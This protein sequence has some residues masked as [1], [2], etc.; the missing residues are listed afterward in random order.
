MKAH[1]ALKCP[2]K[3]IFIFFLRST[4]QPWG[5]SPQHPPGGFEVGRKAHLGASWLRE[6]PSFQRRLGAP[7]LLC[8]AFKDHRMEGRS[9]GNV[10]IGQL[11]SLAWHPCF[12]YS[13]NFSDFQWVLLHHAGPC[14][15]EQSVRHS[16]HFSS[17]C[18]F[19]VFCLSCSLCWQRPS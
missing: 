1:L 2:L 16:E 6:P 14:A 5:K 9:T 15:L 10:L 11:A 3:K 19:S 17:G 18:E 8:L 13:S 4:T 12:F 7:I